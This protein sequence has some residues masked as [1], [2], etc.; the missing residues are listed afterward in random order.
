MEAI[1]NFS[2]N[3]LDVAFLKK[4]KLIQKELIE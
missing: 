2:I 3:S 4:A 1:F